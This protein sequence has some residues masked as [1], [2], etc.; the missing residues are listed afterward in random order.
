MGNTISLS[1]DSYSCA[2]ASGY[3]IYRKADSTGY[4]HSYCETGVPPYLGYSKIA[5]LSDIAST[6]YLDDNK[7]AGLMRGLKYCYLIVAYYPDKA[8]S[9]ASN[10]A[11]AILKKDLAVITHASVLT[12]NETSGSI[13]VAWA[14]P[15][16]LDTIQIPGPY[17]Y[18]IVRS[19]SDLP[20]QFTAIDSLFNLNDTVIT[21]LA[22]NTTR[23]SYL[24]RIDLYNE[25][26]GNRFM[27][28]SSQVASS[29][30]VTPGPTDKMIK[31]TWNNNIPWTNHLFVI[32]R[33]D[34]DGISYD[35]IGTST[36]PIY[37]DKE[38][39]NGLSYCYKIK[40]IGNYSAQGFIDPIVNFSQESCAIPLDNIPPCPPLLA[41]QTICEESVNVL[42]WTK[43]ADSCPDDIARYYIYYTQ[44]NGR[45]V[46][47][48]SIYN[49]GDTSYTHKPVNTISGCYAVA[50][51][52]SLGNL[53]DTSNII[54]IEY[55]NCPQYTLPN[56]FTPNGDGK[57]DYF[58]PFPGYT[59]VSEVTMKIFDRWGKLVFDTNNPAIQWD[60]KDKTT[61]QPCS[62][63]TYFYVCDVYEITLNGITK[64]NL[65][66]SLTILR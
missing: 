5:V 26:P 47:I 46:L 58:I 59:S 39:V 23:Y 19:R 20:D 62:D 49:A 65:H 25:T 4:I 32:Y 37:N 35:S 55:T 17:K 33:K 29:I 50:A 64:R 28:G 60:G 38:L 3:Y 2:N 8:E 15:T 7:G 43:P 63:G 22:L 61:N 13:Y 66:G 21:D 14:K 31:L 36:V 45:P 1:W 30:F 27:V 16:E 10:E 53:S 40:T 12:T 9:Y 54:C 11:C 48:D 24:Y 6:T 42:S 44:I 51:M 18:V 41:I 56:I 34:P 52:D 57:N